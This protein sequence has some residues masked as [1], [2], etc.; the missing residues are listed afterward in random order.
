M[1]FFKKLLG[2][3]GESGSDRGRKKDKDVKGSRSSSRGGGSGSHDGGSVASG[4]DR[5]AS[6]NIHKRSGSTAS[7]ESGA[8]RERGAKAGSAGGSNRDSTRGAQQAGYSQR[9]RQRSPSS[10]S[11]IEDQR[12]QGGA[13]GGAN[14]RG[15]SANSNTRARAELTYS[16][17]EQQPVSARSDLSTARPQSSTSDAPEIDSG[18]M[19]NEKDLPK[20]HLCAWQNKPELF[21]KY[22]SNGPNVTDRFSRY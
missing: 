2:K 6:T 17:R 19:V 12:N 15:G 10:D 22:L 11:S 9:G 20:L 21:K 1:S 4:G 14:G 5:R 18:Y 7:Q 16:P 13:G 8:S 3:K